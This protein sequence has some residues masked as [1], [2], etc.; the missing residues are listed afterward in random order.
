MSFVLSLIA[1]V[2]VAF[3]AAAFAVGAW[4]WWQLRSSRSFWVLIRTMQVALI[5]LAAASGLA[6]LLGEQ[7]S[8]DL[9]YVYTLT[10]ILV[11]FAAEQLRV[12]A[13]EA[14]LDKRG[15]ENAKAIAKLPDEVGRSI[16]LEIVRRE[17][18]VMTLA[19]L[20]SAG[21]AIRALLYTV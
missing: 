12:G 1:A 16:V 4:C 8:N 9:Y 19:A 5:T 18:G 20:V 13:A 17:I 21:L 15:I 3:G 11:S 7:P 6:L 2:A 14:V 10:P